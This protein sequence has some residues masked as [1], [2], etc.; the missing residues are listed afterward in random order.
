MSQQSQKEM[1]SES[2]NHLEDDA[3]LHGFL[4]SP[5]ELKMENMV[6]MFESCQ[7]P[8]IMWENLVFEVFQFVQ[9]LAVTPH[10]LEPHQF[11]FEMV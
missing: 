9:I 11:D 2:T 1:T 8:K 7:H 4:A 5:T 3:H 6:V 10:L